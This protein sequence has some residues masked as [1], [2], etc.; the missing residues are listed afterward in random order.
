MNVLALEPHYGG[1]HKA[2]LDGWTAHS[3]HQWTVVGLPA[4]KWKWRMRHA[5]LTLSQQVLQRGVNPSAW[6]VVFCSDM[7]A[8][9]EFRGLADPSVARLPAVIY[10]HENQ[11]TYPCRDS[12]ERDYHF[13]FT[14]FTAACAADRVWFNSAFHRDE[15]LTA[16]REFLARMPDYQPL[17]EVDRIREKSDVRSPGIAAFSARGARPTGPLRIL[18]AA[19]WEHDKAPETFF[20]AARVLANRN[21][22]FRISVI[23]QSFRET[24]AIF[25][26]STTKTRSGRARL[27]T[28][29]CDA[30]VSQT[31]ILYRTVSDDDGVK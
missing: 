4:Y 10:F 21:V 14:N 22:D 31:R 18:W 23:G 17:E 20:A 30:P 2:F 29:T 11:L 1:S 6:D 27:T 12:R 24:P 9:A 13:A 25:V 19:R 7:L 15:F 26:R 8:L 3:R 28:K 5:P 16:L